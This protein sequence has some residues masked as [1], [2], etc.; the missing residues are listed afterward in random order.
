MDGRR[1]DGRSDDGRSR[2]RQG[3]ESTD[4]RS[5]TVAAPPEAKSGTFTIRARAF[6]NA[7]GPWV[8]QVAG[9]LPDRD[10]AEQIRLA[11]TKGVHLLL[12]RLTR[13]HAVAFQAG[14]DGRVMFALPWL[15]C[16]IV[17]TTDTD[18]R[19]DPDA[20]RTE[21]ADVEYLLAETN[22][23][24]PSAAATGS[25][26]ITTFAGLRPLLAP[27]PGGPGPRAPTPRP[28]AAS[29]AWCGGGPTS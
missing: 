18:Y 23:L 25:D 17:G 10:G 8:E 4:P 5:R 6:V 27:A 19:G 22:R 3:A 12:P 26:V 11:P 15:D 7:A 24:F 1:E 28:A 21:P 9:L 16:T 2:D 20:A 14:R 13:S 29:T